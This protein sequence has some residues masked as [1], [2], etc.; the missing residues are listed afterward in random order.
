VPVGLGI[1]SLKALG[2]ALEIDLD[3]TKAANHS[4]RTAAIPQH[5]VGS[6][7]SV[8]KTRHK[9]CDA[10]MYFASRVAAMCDLNIKSKSKNCLILDTCCILHNVCSHFMILYT[11]QWVWNHVCARMYYF[12]LI[13][14]IYSYTVYTIRTPYTSVYHRW[15]LGSSACRVIGR[16]FF[17][18]HCWQRWTPRVGSLSAALAFRHWAERPDLSD[19]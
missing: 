11:S 5:F 1:R 7:A 16:P 15:I 17:S 18:G 3:N 12:L 8:R 14:S 6:I 4:I 2:F 9:L 10:Q 19:V 13:P